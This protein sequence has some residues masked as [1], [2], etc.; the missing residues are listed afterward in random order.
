MLILYRYIWLVYVYFGLSADF[1]YP[2]QFSPPLPLIIESLL[3]LLTWP[4]LIFPF[5][6]VSL[7]AMPPYGL[8]SQKQRGRRI[9]SGKVCNCWAVAFLYRTKVDPQPLYATGVVQMAHTRAN[10]INSFWPLVS[11]IALV[12]WE[13]RFC[14]WNCLM[15][16]H[17]LYN[18]H[19]SGHYPSS[20]LLFETKNV[21]DWILS[22]F[23]SE[24]RDRI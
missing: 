6:L 15:M 9:L 2:R 20:C 14:C 16:N 24:D 19:N 7:G 5:K 1:D 21:G 8:V 18:L 17:L 22:L 12:N 23:L 13:R 3:Y 4:Y 11:P 10:F